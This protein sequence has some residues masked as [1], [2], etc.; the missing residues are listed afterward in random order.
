MFVPA[1]ILLTPPAV[2][3]IIG[4]VDVPVRDIF[5][6]AVIL[7]TP[8]VAPVICDSKLFISRGTDQVF[9]PEEVIS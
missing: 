6:P 9:A 4:L 5:V 2:E 7:W 8:L 1:V 3:L